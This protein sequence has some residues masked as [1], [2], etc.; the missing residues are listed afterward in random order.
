MSE[1]TKIKLG[2]MPPLSGI[3]SLYGEEISR[4]GKIATEEINRN[5]GVLGRDIELVILDDGSLPESS[6]HAATRLID[7]FGCMAIIG[8]LLSN[9]RIAV[10][11]LVAE[12]RKIP[13]LNFSFYEG[14]ISGRYFFSFAAL[15]NQQIEKMIPYMAN[16]FG[17]K[18]F[19]AGNNYE[20][21]RGSIDAAK[22]VLLKENGEIIGEEY[23][24][25]GASMAEVEALVEMVGSSG[26]DVFVPYFAGLDQI[27][28]LNHFTKMGLKRKMAVVMG[29]YDEMMASLLK[30]EVREGFF[31]SNTYFMSLETAKNRAYLEI[32]QKQKDVTGIH[33]IGNGVLTN[34]GEGTYVCVHAFAK[35][36]KMAGE[37]DREK[38]VEALESVSVDAP[39]GVVCMD[40]QTHHAIVN[41]YLAQC[42]SNGR[43]AIIENFGQIVPMIPQRYS[44]SQITVPSFPR[45][46]SETLDRGLGFASKS[47]LDSTDIAVIATDADGIILQS[48]K[49]AHELFGYSDVELAGISINMLVPPHFRSF[50]KEAIKSFVASDTK[51]LRMGKRGEIAGYKKDGTFFSAEASIAKFQTENEWILVATVMDITARKKAEE[52]LTWRAT[53]D[54]LTRLPNRALIKE[55][56]ENALARTKRSGSQVGLLFIDLD[57][58]K[59]INDTYGHNAGDKLLID[60]AKKLTDHVRPGDTVAR[61]GGDEFVVMCENIGNES[62]LIQL[63]ERINDAL[64]QPL[65]VENKEIISTAS[66]GLTYGSGATHSAD[67]LLRESDTAMYASKQH[68]RD[69]WHIFSSELHERSKQRLEI[70]S[71]LRS[72]IEKGEMEVVYQPI[73]AAQNGAIQGAEALLRWKT[74]EKNISPAI[75]IPLAEES[76]SMLSIGKW[77]FEQVCKTQHFLTQKYGNHAPYISV[78]ISV[79]QI[80]SNTIVEDFR[81]IL[82][83]EGADASKVLLEITET[84]IMSNVE[85]NISTL[86]GLRKLGMSIAV[87]DFGT[88]YSSFAQLLRLPISHIK[89]DKEFVDGLDQHENS[90]L[91]TSTIIKM[92]KNLGKKTVAEGVESELQLFELRANGVDY[93]QGYYFYKPL[94]F[95]QFVQALENQNLIASENSDIFTAMY[96][97]EA[98]DAMDRHT[99]E[100]LVQQ[101]RKFNST[102]GIT[103]YLLYEKGYFLQLL[104]G[105]K[106]IV[107]SLLLKISQ[108]GRHKNM[109]TILKG[110]TKSR[111]FHEWS[112]GYW[113]IDELHKKFDFEEL[114]VKRFGFAE[115]S[116]DPRVCYAL[117]H[118]LSRENNQLP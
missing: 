90:K 37:V 4:A 54:A 83:K 42:G 113:I 77:V 84:S 47:I 114:N 73:V 21:P 52:D 102:H 34:F 65:I 66:I 118:S 36:C 64:R 68:G 116:Q 117:F 93:I 72:A 107:D 2:L 9:S 111:L 81:E 55:R 69:T 99:I 70:E 39:Q 6:V 92:A 50:H 25:I 85:K 71:G 80:D 14:S 104:E 79:K 109:K 57:K 17:S 45:K 75:F 87:D 67:D 46:R 95:G 49:G 32:L 100:S 35:A 59:L 43:F 41:S 3:V 62:A 61:L 27:N 86:E 74:N 26:A 24:S 82:Q 30:P 31:S 8:N 44:A 60:F 48:N 16:R 101:S 33:P 7:E 11:N 15:P 98:V 63:A 18:M 115:L 53:H 19:L 108:D 96:V 110:L 38:I 56:L 112:M 5:G 91:V 103:G 51:E 88:G 105:R 89:I 58:F 28:L 94:A 76:G 106:E 23:L 97:S 40:R 1:K 12:P 78:N 20:W 29:H 22:R 13:Y 10:A